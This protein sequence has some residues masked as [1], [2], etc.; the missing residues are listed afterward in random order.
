MKILIGASST[1]DSV[2]L[3]YNSLKNT[4]HEIITR[5]VKLDACNED[6]DQYPLVCEWMYNNVRSFDYGFAEFER[7]DQKTK[8]EE[9]Y[10]NAAT[11][12]LSVLAMCANYHNV[13]LIYLGFNTFN[14]SPSNWFFQTNE[15]IEQFYT[16]DNPWYR[17][18]NHYILKERT[19]A[20]IDWPFMN[21][22]SRPIGRWETFESIPIELRK[23]VSTGCNKCGTC[24]QCRARHLYYFL[25]KRGYTAEHIDDYIQRHCKYGKYFQPGTKKSD[26]SMRNNSFSNLAMIDPN[27]KKKVFQIEEV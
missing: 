6:L 3:L 9:T 19:D 5:I 20:S 7:D 23:L 8:I 17:E 25:K 27:L 15:S 12:R 18:I 22:K 14:W 10:T 4:D 24:F 13:D 2:A 11:E 26:V 16:K 21:R 1:P